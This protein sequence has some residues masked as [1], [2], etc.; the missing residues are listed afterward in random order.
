MIFQ[1][2]AEMFSSLS[3]QM[4]TEVLRICRFKQQLFL[5]LTSLCAFLPLEHWENSGNIRHFLALIKLKH[6]T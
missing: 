5:S 6:L 3:H 2:H 1:K 4:H